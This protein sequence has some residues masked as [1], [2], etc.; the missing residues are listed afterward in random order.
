MRT[1]Q[2][3]L[4]IVIALALPPALFSQTQTIAGTVT[5]SSSA[6]ISGARVEVRNTNTGAAQSVTTDGQGRYTVPQLSIGAYEVQAASAGFQTGLRRGINL[7]VG[8]QFVIDFSL[9]VGQASETVTVEGAV[10]QVETT[11]STLSQLVEQKQIQEFTSFY[12]C[13]L[14]VGLARFHTGA[15]KTGE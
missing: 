10:A 5:D 13:H 7:S 3:Y 4:L 14:G 8:D 9:A 12:G 6:A 1:L 2:T 11:S 15:I